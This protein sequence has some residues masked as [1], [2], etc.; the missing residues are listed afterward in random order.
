MI[1]DVRNMLEKIESIRED[2]YKNIYDDYDMTL[3]NCIDKSIK[4]LEEMLSDREKYLLKKSNDKHELHDNNN[5]PK[6]WNG[7]KG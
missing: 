6:T 3:I 1:S 7:P 4:V 2:Y 5:K